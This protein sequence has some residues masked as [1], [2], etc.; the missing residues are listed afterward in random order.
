MLLLVQIGQSPC[1]P[2]VNIHNEPSYQTCIPQYI[3]LTLLWGNA[4]LHNMSIHC[5]TRWGNLILVVYNFTLIKSVFTGLLGE[6]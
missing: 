4:C 1:C 2:D 5:D 3:A 6:G